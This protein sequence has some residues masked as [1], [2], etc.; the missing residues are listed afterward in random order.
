MHGSVIHGGNHQQYAQQPGKNQEPEEESGSEDEDGSDETE[1]DVTDNEGGNLRRPQH[2]GGLFGGGNSYPSTTSGPPE[3]F[4]NWDTEIK[5]EMTRDTKQ[6]DPA[7]TRIESDFW[8]P[9]QP[10]QFERMPPN[11]GAEPPLK[12]NVFQQSQVIR[13][14]QST[15]N[16]ANGFGKGQIS[17]ARPGNQLP[18]YP[19]AAR[20]PAPSAGIARQNA[21]PQA[22]KLPERGSMRSLRGPATPPVQTPAPTLQ[23]ARTSQTIEAASV[24]ETRQDHVEDYD[25]PT[26][27]KMSY[28]SLKNEKFDNVP[29]GS[30]QVLSDDMQKKPLEDRLQ[31][32]HEKLGDEDQEKFV[33][34]LSLEEWEDAGQWFV[35]RFSDIVKQ[36]TQARQSKRKLAREFEEE[37]EQRYRH[38]EKRQQNVE[39]ALRTMQRQGEHLVLPRTPRSSREPRNV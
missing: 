36:A 25:L 33:H 35:N 20:E 38:V 37:V 30:P 23:Q 31:H 14:N 8:K 6:P 21:P 39:D 24:E 1:E 4:N 17:S 10:Y 32:V 16:A 26:L 28:E 18:T 19:Q 22:M 9:G 29:R 34:S 27:Y 2:T 5:K 12:P 15:A 13:Q 3:D 7:N 11:F